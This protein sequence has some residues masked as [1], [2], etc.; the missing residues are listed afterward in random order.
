MLL[1]TK[2]NAKTP[3]PDDKG[4]ILNKN[5]DAHKKKQEYLSPE[6]KDLFAKNNTAAQHKYRKLLS[7]EQKVQVM[8]NKATAHKKQYELLPP[9]KKARCMEIRTEQCHEHS[10]EE[11]KKFSAQIRSVAA[12]L[13]EKKLISINQLLNFSRLYFTAGLLNIME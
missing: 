2:S 7:P 12:T 1:H 3:C 13:Y 9:K 5:A 8:T 4:Q 10:T 11:E 6:N